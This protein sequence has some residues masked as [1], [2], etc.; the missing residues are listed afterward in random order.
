M[1]KPGV[2]P[3]ILHDILFKKDTSVGP[4]PEKS[5]WRD[6]G[7]RRFERLRPFRFERLRL[8]GDTREVKEMRIGFSLV[9][10]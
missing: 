9:V 1:S 8:R 4:A 3:V 10:L 5:S 7:D 2:L 6:Q